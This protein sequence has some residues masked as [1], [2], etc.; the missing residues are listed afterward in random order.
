MLEAVKVDIVV[1]VGE[2]EERYHLEGTTTMHHA[3]HTHTMY[4]YVCSKRRGR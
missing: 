1:V 2:R 4:E 3:L